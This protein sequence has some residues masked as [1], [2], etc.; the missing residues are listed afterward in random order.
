M[1]IKIEG[2]KMNFAQR[3][4]NE[5]AIKNEIEAMTESVQKILKGE[6]IIFQNFE[7]MEELFSADL[8][9]KKLL[10][11]EN[12]NFVDVIFTEKDFEN[13]KHVV[14]N[15]YDGTKEK[16][17]KNGHNFLCFRVFKEDMSKNEGKS[18]EKV[19]VEGCRDFSSEI[20]TD[21]SSFSV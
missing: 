6:K 17:Y 21:E 19:F 7:N 8:G 14:T 1:N 18:Y 13:K 9:K 4:E 16:I 5:K 3:K 12:K 2:L 11:E 20:L 15:I 10:I